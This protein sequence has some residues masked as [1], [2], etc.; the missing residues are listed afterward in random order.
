M[1][2]PPLDK[3]GVNEGP[4]VGNPEGA[5]FTL[6]TLPDGMRA[7][8]ELAS[9][10]IMHPAVGPAVEARTLYV[11]QS[12]LAERLCQTDTT[13]PVR[14]YDVGL[15][16]AA[17]ASAALEC[18]ASLGSK[19]TRALEIVSFEVDTEPL[20]LALGDLDGFP[21]LR[22][23]AEAARAVLDHGTF[24][25]PGLRWTLHRGNLLEQLAHAAPNPELVFH[26]PFSPETNG[27]LWT[28]A[29]FSQLR[30]KCRP[31]ADPLGTLLLTYSASTRT[32]VSMLLG[33]WYVGVGIPIGYKKE[34]TVAAT[35]AELLAKPLDAR[36]LERWKRSSARDPWGAALDSESE[37]GV[38]EHPLFQ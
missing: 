30:A 29:A 32:R 9:G 37:R 2:E 14:L 18:A 38:I 34:T 21:F 33:G 16:G 10:E 6:V 20:E 24:E 17:I 26:D 11:E 35:R 28:P 15:G 27:S 12:R 31:E 1:G 3:L 19:R 23:W 22:P 8:R 7:V 13:E 36:W 25:A 5:R 4:H